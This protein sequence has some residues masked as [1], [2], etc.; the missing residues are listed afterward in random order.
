MHIVKLKQK[1]ISTV[2]IE[3]LFSCDNYKLQ[4][5]NENYN[6]ETKQLIYKEKL[7]FNIQKY[8]KGENI[9]IKHR[10]E[11]FDGNTANE[12]SI[13]VEKD[14]VILTIPKI[15]NKKAKR[16]NCKIEFYISKNFKIPIL[17]DCEIIPIDFNFLVYDFSN[18]C[19]RRMI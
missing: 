17:I 4:F 5:K 14:K 18:H 11:S 13:H 1:Y 7:I 15:E 2:P 10:I 16:L 8:I 19:F 6:L 12:P 9:N 3:L